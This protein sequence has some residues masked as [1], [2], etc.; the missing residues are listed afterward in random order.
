MGA[1]RGGIITSAG[2]G[3][4]SRSRAAGNIFDTAGCLSGVSER[5]LQR[6]SAIVGEAYLIDGQAS[7]EQLHLMNVTR[8]YQGFVTAVSTK[9]V[10]IGGNRRTPQHPALINVPTMVGEL[11]GHH[12]RIRQRMFLLTSIGGV[13]QV[14]KESL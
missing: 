13:R 3:G 12:A 9:S 1:E 8:S 14:K 4:G 7:D 6:E 5:L 2:G 11:F 10:V